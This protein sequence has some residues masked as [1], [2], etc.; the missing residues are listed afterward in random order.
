MTDEEPPSIEDVYD[1]I[2]ESYAA[3]YWQEN[4]HQSELEFPATTGLL[5]AVDLA[6]RRVLDAG[7][8]SGVYTD[9]LLDRGADVVAT[10]VSEAMLEETEALV[11]DDAELHQADLRDPLSFAEDDSFDGVVCAQVLDHVEDLSVPIGEFARVLRPGGFIV[12]SVRHPV[13]NAL[14]Y[15]TWPYFETERQIE[16]WGVDTPH[17]PRPMAGILNT[18]LEAGFRLESVTEPTPTD[19]FHERDPEEAERLTHRPQFLCLRARLE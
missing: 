10:D 5:K 19:R 13:R 8:G 11:G 3:T 15:E 17:Y 16:D 7:C 2:A 6:D 18:L 9:W 14:A 12:L 4:L 1:R